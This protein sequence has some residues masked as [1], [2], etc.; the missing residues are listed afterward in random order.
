[1]PDYVEQIEIYCPNCGQRNYGF[2]NGKGSVI[3]QCRKCRRC[4]TSKR[5]KEKAKAVIT[6]SQ[7]N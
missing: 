6:I 3:L 1:M 4:I 2:K 5:M 7:H